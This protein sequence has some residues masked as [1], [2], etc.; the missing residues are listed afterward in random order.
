MR[1]VPR[2]VYRSQPSADKRMQMVWIVMRTVGT[3][4]DCIR[5]GRLPRNFPT[6]LAAAEEIKR[7][8][9]FDRA[10]ATRLGVELADAD[11]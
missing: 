7:Q 3:H 11:E 6:A 2:P 9:R 4:E 1:R 8:Q 5:I 10:A